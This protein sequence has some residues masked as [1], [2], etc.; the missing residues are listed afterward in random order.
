M[1]IRYFDSGCGHSAG[2]IERLNNQPD[3]VKKYLII[4]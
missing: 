2:L 1:L 4:R 3:K